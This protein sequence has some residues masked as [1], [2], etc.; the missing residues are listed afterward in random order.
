[1][2][3][4]VAMELM[5]EENQTITQLHPLP[6]NEIH[7]LPTIRVPPPISTGI[8]S[9]SDWWAFPRNLPK[10]D[11]VVVRWGDEVPFDIFFEF[12]RST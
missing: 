7:L 5:L 4:I 6:I 2:C 9:N 10:L 1:M 8:R 12:E 3:L 11:K